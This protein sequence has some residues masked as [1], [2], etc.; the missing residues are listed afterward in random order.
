MS[1]SARGLV[2]IALACATRNRSYR[3]AHVT[4]QIPGETQQGSLLAVGLAA[5][6]I[7]AS[8]HGLAGPLTGARQRDDTL[9][10]GESLMGDP[11][12]DHGADHGPGGCTVRHVLERVLRALA[13]TTWSF[14]TR[15]RPGVSMVWQDHFSTKL[16]ISQLRCLEIK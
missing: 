2:C 5:V 13:A 10:D 6:K 12:V 14:M 15:P 16:S 4:P 9:S 1:I 7:G 11:R 3:D 8:Q